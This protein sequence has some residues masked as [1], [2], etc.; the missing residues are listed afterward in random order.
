MTHPQHLLLPCLSFDFVVWSGCEASVNTHTQHFGFDEL[1]NIW[2]Y[3]SDR[4]KA[5]CEDVLD[6][7]QHTHF[8]LAWSFAFFSV[9]KLIFMKRW[10]HQRNKKAICYSIWNETNRLCVL[11]PALIEFVYVIMTNEYI[12][13]MVVVCVCKR[14]HCRG[15]LLF[16]FV[17]NL[18]MA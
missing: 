5:N 12:M 1:I 16:H 6:K 11:Q 10:I 4:S 15:V 8:A 14:Y 7:Y 18:S 2:E 3:A 9:C 17:G 13:V